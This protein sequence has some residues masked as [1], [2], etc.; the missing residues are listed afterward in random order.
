M[1]PPDLGPIPP[2]HYFSP[3]L[4]TG[5]KVKPP[6]G[7][8]SLLARSPLLAMKDWR[9][10]KEGPDCTLNYDHRDVWASTKHRFTYLADSHQDRWTIPHPVI[11]FEGDCEDFALGCRQR[12]RLMDA[13]GRLLLCKER[14]MNAV[15]HCVFLMGTW[16]LDC[17]LSQPCH[18]DTFTTMYNLHAVSSESL[19]GS[20]HR[21]VI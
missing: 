18:L 7:Y 12:A 4:R 20:W 19:L 15:L 3:R 11:P 21:V 8:L 16:V 2:E 10:H 17:R 9:Q 14:K 5:A 13:R 6:R 1:I